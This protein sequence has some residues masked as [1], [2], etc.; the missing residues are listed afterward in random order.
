MNTNR[1][2]QTLPAVKEECVLFVSQ[3]K[4]VQLK[5][6]AYWAVV[7]HL[8]YDKSWETMTVTIRPIISEPLG[9][10]LVEDNRIVAVKVNGSQ[11]ELE[12]EYAKEIKTVIAK[13]EEHDNE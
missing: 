4:Q 7:Q 13:L 9:Y 6:I 3:K 12:K 2:I 1:V 5:E 11:K 8:D 10:K